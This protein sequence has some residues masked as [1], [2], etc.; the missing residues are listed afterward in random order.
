MYL[1]DAWIR[2]EVYAGADTLTGFCQVFD[3]VTKCFSNGWVL[4]LEVGYF[5]ARTN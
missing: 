2:D 3:A 1:D 5:A 4:Q